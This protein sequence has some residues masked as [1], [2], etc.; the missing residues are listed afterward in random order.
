MHIF[1]SFTTIILFL[2]LFPFILKAINKISF[3]IYKRKIIKEISKQF[4]LSYSDA[5]TIYYKNLEKFTN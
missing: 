3:Y 2:I 1:L 5:E 4:N